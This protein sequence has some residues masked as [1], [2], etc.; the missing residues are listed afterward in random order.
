MN[1]YQVLSTAFGLLL[2]IG[3]MYGTHVY[4]TSRWEE[5]SAS[6]SE[7]RPFQIAGSAWCDETR[8]LLDDVWVVR[9]SANARATNA[10]VE[11]N[12]KSFEMTY[13]PKTDTWNQEIRGITLSS[14]C[15]RLNAISWKFK[16]WAADGQYA[17]TQPILGKMMP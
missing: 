6:A 7:P 16:A 4:N 12:G 5:A 9:A 2:A 13:D 17:E 11:A 14:D 10:Q 3:L 8:A 15:D 1:R